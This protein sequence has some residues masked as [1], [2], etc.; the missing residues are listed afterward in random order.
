MRHAREQVSAALKPT[1][2]N[3]DESREEKKAHKQL[4][5]MVKAA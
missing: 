2:T 4:D 3:E 5:R 1:I